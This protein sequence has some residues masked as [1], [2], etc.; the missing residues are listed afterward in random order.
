M[1]GATVYLSIQTLWGVAAPS[2]PIIVQGKARRPK[3]LFIGATT[4]NNTQ[5]VFALK[6]VRN[7]LAEE[8]RPQFDVCY[9]PKSP[10]TAL[11]LSILLGNL[12]IDRFYVGSLKMGFL[13]LFTFGGLGII[14]LYDWFAIRSKCR[15]SNI[16]RAQDVATGVG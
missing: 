5:Y 1:C 8:R 9:A 16:D 4:M 11:I 2:V 6:Q 7:T 14:S 13:K 15:K 3:L 12:G 10:D